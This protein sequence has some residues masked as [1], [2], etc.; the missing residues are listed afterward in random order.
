VDA[1][2]EAY[3]RAVELDR[4][5]AIYGANLAF[6]MWRGRG[7][8]GSAHAL[9][10]EIVGRQRDA[11]T[12]SRLAWFNDV[13]FD[14][15]QDVAQQLYE[16]ALGMA[17]QDRWLHG[18]FGDFLRRSGDADAARQHFEQAITGE[19]PDV[20]ALAW[21]AELQLLEGSFESGEQLLRRALRRRRGDPG[22]VAALAATRTLRGAADRDVE[23]MYR[24]ALEWQPNQPL[25]AL[26]LAQILLRRDN[27]DEEARLLLA[28]VSRAELTPEMRLELLFYGLAYSVEG[29]EDACVEMRRL[30][31]EDVRVTAWDLSQEIEAA[32]EQGHDHSELLA[33]VIERDSQSG[34]SAY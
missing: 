29:F 13:A 7:D 19:H 9:L 17:P 6:F 2:E 26:N 4:D 33:Q 25:A 10:L 21:Y 27:S 8:R 24:Q 1:A 22:L 23:P 30:L 16:E 18:R 32:R 28:E 20:D 11:F 15:H 12:L 3:R 34:D 5:S 31:D 14:D